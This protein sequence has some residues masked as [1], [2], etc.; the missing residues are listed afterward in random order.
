[1]K[2]TFNLA[3]AAV[4]IA[5]LYFMVSEGFNF[6]ILLVLIFALLTW[7]IHHIPKEHKDL[8]NAQI[9]EIES[10]T[11]LNNSNAAFTTAN[12]LYLKEQAIWYKNRR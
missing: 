11:R 1:M 12:A 9:N 3:N 7:G 8:V 5:C 6:W 10:R 2:E 4:I